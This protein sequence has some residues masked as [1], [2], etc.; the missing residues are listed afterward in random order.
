MNRP[1]LT[2]VMVFLLAGSLCVSLSGDRQGPLDEDLQGRTL[3]EVLAMNRRACGGAEKREPMTG[4]KMTGKIDAVAEGFDMPMTL[5]RKRPDKL[6]VETTFQGKVIVQAFDG[7]KAW[8][9]MPFLVAAPQEMP[10]E[11]AA[12]FADQAGFAE[13]LS[14]YRQQGQALELLGREEMAGV[15]V[16]HLKRRRADGCEIDH[17]LDAGSGSELKSARRMKI[18]EAEALVEILYRDYRLVDGRLMPFVVENQLNGQSRVLM[19]FASIAADPGLGDD[20]FAMPVKTG[21]SKPKP[22]KTESK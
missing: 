12:A 6:R 17:F 22:N 15:Q 10:E 7:K 2:I 16:F 5:W 8:W 9:I 20:F 18:G 13:S 3:E 19:T 4:W 11:Q 1:I 21:A 14:A